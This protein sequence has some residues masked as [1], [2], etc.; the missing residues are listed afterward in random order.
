MGRTELCVLASN[1]QLTETAN[2]VY[3]KEN[4]NNIV[5]EVVKKQEEGGLP[6]LHLLNNTV[7]TLG[8]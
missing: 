1:K 6:D 2:L 3:A 8:K 4:Q 7:V 5:V